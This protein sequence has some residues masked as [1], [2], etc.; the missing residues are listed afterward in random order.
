MLLGI[1]VAGVIVNPWILAW[2]AVMFIASLAVANF[3]LVAARPM[4]RIESVTRSPFYDQLGAALL[5][6]PTIRA[7]DYAVTYNN[8]IHRLIDDMAAASWYNNTTMRFTSWAIGLT[9]MAFS[10]G[11]CILIVLTPQIDAAKAGFALAFALEFAQNLTEGLTRY[12]FLST[13]AS[14]SFS[15]SRGEG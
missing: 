9:G 2:A 11:M 13:V 6:V 15:R 1:V 4:R 5:G 8:R 7:S 3:C 10:T 12:V 14:H